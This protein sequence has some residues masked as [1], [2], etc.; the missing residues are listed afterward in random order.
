[1]GLSFAI[2]IDVAMDIGQQL[3]ATGRVAR[4]R[5]GVVI[6]EVTKELAE[7]FGLRK[8]Q[9]ALVSALEKGG[10]AQAAGIE[11]SDIILRF[12]GKPVNASADLPRIVAATKPGSRAVVEVWRKGASREFTV[13]VADTPEDRGGPRAGPRGQGPGGP[14][15]GQGPQQRQSLKPFGL[16]VI[17]L[18]AEQRAQ[19]RLTGGALVEDAQGLAARAGIRRGDVIAAVNN[20]E[21]RSAEHL[22]SVLG[23]AERGRNVALLVRRGD[24]ALYVPLRID[25]AGG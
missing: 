20:I 7:S 3:R 18:S 8:P 15:G 4:G 22:A 25:P 16:T 14:P 13:T 19:L 12:D 17:D 24:N 9:G 21:I 11:A 23:Q 10:P 5:I 6:Q 2:P 1:M